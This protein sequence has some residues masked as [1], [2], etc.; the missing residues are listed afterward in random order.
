MGCWSQVWQG[1]LEDDPRLG[2][3]LTITTQE[4]IAKICDI[5]MADRRVMKHYTATELGFSE[6]CISSLDIKWN[7]LASNMSRENLV[8]FKA[9]P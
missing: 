4:T 8:I 5:I 1:K 7:G 2:R 6:E 9:D 3:P